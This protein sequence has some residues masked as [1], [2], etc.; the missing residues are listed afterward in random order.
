M[1]TEVALLVQRAE[2]PL[3]NDIQ[4]A[5]TLLQATRISDKSSALFRKKM[6]ETHSLP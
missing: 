3:D 1:R 6:M 4:T 5:V 2:I